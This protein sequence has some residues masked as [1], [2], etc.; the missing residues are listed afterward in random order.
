MSKDGLLPPIFSKVNDKY[1]TPHYS[2]IMT[3][4]SCGIMAGILPIHILGELVSIGTLMA[5]VLV[6]TSIIILRKTRPEV[7]RPFKTPFVPAVPIL[8]IV[9]CFGQMLALPLDT[10]I[11]LF[12]WMA[13]G[14]VFY[15][16]YGIKHS[17]LN[18][19]QE[20]DKK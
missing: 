9:I 10:W 4:L 1:K 8:G 19:E 15:F 16:S 14:L 20:E 12:A 5:F 2:T 18:Q 3:G 11:R 6:C 13:V 17:K 7:N